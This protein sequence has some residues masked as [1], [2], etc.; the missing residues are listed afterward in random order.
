MTPPLKDE[1]IATLVA[2]AERPADDAGLASA[3][4]DAAEALA[5]V[6]SDTIVADLTRIL[7]ALANRLRV[8]GG[9]PAVDRTA[10]RIARI[11]PRT[12]AMAIATGLGDD[13]DERSR[14]LR[15]LDALAIACPA[16]LP[17][18]DALASPTR[19]TSDPDEFAPYVA[20]LLDAV[21]AQAALGSVAAYKAVVRARLRSSRVLDRHA[22]LEWAALSLLTSDERRAIDEVANAHRVA[23]NVETDAF[24]VRVYKRVVDVV[25]D[26]MT[27]IDREM[28][29][30]I[31]SSY[32]D[33]VAL[34]D[35]VGV[36][37]PART[38]ALRSAMLRA[39]GL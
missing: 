11:E 24:D 30:T 21:A 31:D 23:P 39:L 1:R 25:S 16:L 18:I 26:P 7:F 33:E 20:E 14:R 32:V 38:R 10:E 2:L 9:D 6:P 3:L 15:E 36:R 8:T 17:A 5:E 28:L 12:L 19:E 29:S 22:A 13:P 35:E 27:E 34:G 4:R 37:D